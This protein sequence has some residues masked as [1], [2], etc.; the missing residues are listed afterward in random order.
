MSVITQT[1]TTTGTTNWVA[2]AGTTTVQVELWG[3]GGT[4]GPATGTASGAGGGA[5]G[6]YAIKQVTVTPGN[7]YAVVVAAAKTS[8]TTV[9]NGNDSTFATTTV[10]AKGG[11]GGAAATGATSAGGAGSTTGGVGDTV[12]AGGSGATGVSSTSSG[13]GGSGAGSTGTGNSGSA[14]TGGAAK[15]NN[16]GAGGNGVTTANTR[17]A[18]GNY[19]GGG[20]GG[21]SSSATDRAG[22]NGAQGLA[23]LTYTVTDFST[24][25]A[26]FATQDTTNFTWNGAAGVSGGQLVLPCNWGGSFAAGYPNSIVS[27]GSFSLIDDAV[28]IQLVSVSTTA[29]CNAAAQ[30]K[31]YSTADTTDYLDIHW[32]FDG[33]IAWDETVNGAIVQGSTTYS[34]TTHAWWRIR[35]TGGIGGTNFW[36]TSADGTTWSTTLISRTAPAGIDLTSMKLLLTCGYDGGPDIGLLGSAVFDNLN[37]PPGGGGA[38]TSLAPVRRP[39]YGS[40]LQQ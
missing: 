16:G 17:N 30:V 39:N 4:G 24:L 38:A 15:A 27:T 10:V 12:F 9:G 14:G 19:G 28:Y 36:E 40:L 22:G 21:L 29:C 11:V 1:I 2:P 33:T 3:G 13:G 6:Q 32:W 31:V 37:T 8:A 35:N 26:D 18:G 5:G 20:S 7:T 34:P 25:T 23:V